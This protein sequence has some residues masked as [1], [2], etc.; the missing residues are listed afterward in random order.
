MT[1][2]CD[3][4]F[5][6]GFILLRQKQ[7]YDLSFTLTINDNN[8]NSNNNNSNNN[9]NAHDV[10]IVVLFWLLNNKILVRLL[11]KAKYSDCLN[12]IYPQNKIPSVFL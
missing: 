12:I 9:N 5:D 6:L 2:S 4:V 11:Q 1:Q 3:I 8:S 7:G 10:V